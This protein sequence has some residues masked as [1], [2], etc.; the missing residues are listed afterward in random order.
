MSF[1]DLVLLSTIPRKGV[2]WVLGDW[3]I[4]GVDWVYWGCLC[5]GV[6]CVGNITVDCCSSVFIVFGDALTFH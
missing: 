5:W 4:N 6:F 2:G 1:W 3:E